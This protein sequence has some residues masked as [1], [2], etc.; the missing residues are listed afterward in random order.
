MDDLHE[1][2]A[3][4]WLARWFGADVVD[5]VRMHVDAKRYL[6]AVE[7][8]YQE[9]LSPPSQLSL[10]L[11]GGPMTDDEVEAFRESPHAAAAVSLRRWDDAAKDPTLA[12]AGLEEY[13]PILEEALVRATNVVR[14]EQ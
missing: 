2:L 5:P 14:T 3:G 8:D 13:L 10:A 12:V 11:Q 9:Q 6:C 4:R 7:P 1:K